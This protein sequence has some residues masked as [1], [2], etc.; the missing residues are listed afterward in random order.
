MS[1]EATVDVENTERTITLISTA[2]DEAGKAREQAVA[3]ELALVLDNVRV[4]VVEIPEYMAASPPQKAA[5]LKSHQEGSWA[6]VWLTHTSS[7][8]LFRANLW[9]ARDA[10]PLRP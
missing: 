10:K 5:L 9:R 7:E 4:T 2:H 6:F 8:A 3:E 1:D